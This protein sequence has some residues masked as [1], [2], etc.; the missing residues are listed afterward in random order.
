MLRRACSN[1]GV[2]AYLIGGVLDGAYLPLQDRGQEPNNLVVRHRLKWYAYRQPETRQLRPCRM[3]QLAL[4]YEPW[5]EGPLDAT[6]F[7]FDG[8]LA[9]EEVAFAKTL[10]DGPES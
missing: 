9:P 8:L 1:Y 4:D 3:V 6:V 5:V 2:V 7:Q 10:C